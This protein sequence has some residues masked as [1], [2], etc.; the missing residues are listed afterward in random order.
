MIV[1]SCLIFFGWSYSESVCTM[2]SFRVE[3]YSVPDP[4][5]LIQLSSAVAPLV[6]I[7][8]TFIASTLFLTRTVGED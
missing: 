2:L 3:Q 8:G 1:F 5:N 6:A 7:A 4:R